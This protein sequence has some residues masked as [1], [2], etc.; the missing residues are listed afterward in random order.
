M[1]TENIGISR[2]NGKTKRF[3][4]RFVGHC[5]DSTMLPKVLFDSRSICVKV[6]LESIGSG[7][8]LDSE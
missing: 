7:V 1:G 5:G 8:L 3:H 6:H 4:S 2:R